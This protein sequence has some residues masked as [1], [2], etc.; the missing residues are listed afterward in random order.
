[1]DGLSEKGEEGGRAGR[2][3]KM[4]ESCLQSPCIELDPH[5]IHTVRTKSRW[6]EEIFGLGAGGEKSS[7]HYQ[8]AICTVGDK[9]DVH[10]A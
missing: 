4:Q 9:R 6:P 8:S 10:F 1:M 5:N 2:L 3:T 7:G